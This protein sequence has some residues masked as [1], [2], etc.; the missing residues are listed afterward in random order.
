MYIAENDH[1]NTHH[2]LGMK[3]KVMQCLGHAPVTQ[4]V[5]QHVVRVATLVA[6]ELVQ[7]TVTGMLRLFSLATATHRRYCH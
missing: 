3:D 1:C 7:Q 4:R 5:T 2:D 6:M